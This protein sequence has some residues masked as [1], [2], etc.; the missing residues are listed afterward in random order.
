MP[1]IERIAFDLYRLT[2][3]GCQDWIVPI[4]N[5]KSAVG[6]NQ[7]VVCVN[8]RVIQ[9]ERNEKQHLV[10]LLPM[11]FAEPVSILSHCG[12]L[13]TPGHL[14]RGWTIHLSRPKTPRLADAP[15]SFL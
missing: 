6:I 9:T 14:T 11:L 4:D 10:L 8:I 3:F 15:G 2:F 1:N 13:T 12:D 5:V 7:D